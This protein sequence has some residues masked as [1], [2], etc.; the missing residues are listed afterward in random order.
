MSTRQ[1]ERTVRQSV[2]D[3]LI[4]D[5]NRQEP[6]TWDESVAAF[7]ASVM[8]DLEWLLNTRRVH[9]PPPPALE[10]VRRSVYAF[11]LRDLSSRSADSLETRSQLQ[12]EVQEAIATFEPRLSKVRVSLVTPAAGDRRIRFQIEGE[13]RTDPSPEAVLFETTLDVASKAMVIQE[14]ADA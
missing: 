9:P 8:R 13:L 3:R 10:L 2:L 7:K 5:P 1:F 6:R 12:R 11:G 4:D 14:G